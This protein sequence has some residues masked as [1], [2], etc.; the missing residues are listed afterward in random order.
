MIRGHGG[1]IHEMAQQLGCE[2]KDIFDMSSNVNPLGPP[3]GLITFLIENI[4]AI[5]ALPEVDARGAIQAFANRYGVDSDLVLAGNGTTQF[6]YAIPQV[7]E[8]RNALIIGPTYADYADACAMHRVRHMFFILDDSNGFSFDPE[9]VKNQ[10]RSA[11]TVFICNPNNPTGSLIPK[12]VLRE[13]IGE[14][15]EKHFIV[16]ES[17]LPFVIDGD[18]ESVVDLGFSNVI[19]L[20]SMSK[21]FRI[22]G[23]RIGFLISSPIIIEKFMRYAL[24][25]SANSL[26]QIAVRYL[27]ENRLETDAF[28]EESK[29][30]LETEKND[31]IGAFK[32]IPGIHMYPSTTSFV[33]AKLY[34][35]HTA[36]EVYEYL[37]HRRILIRRCTNFKGLSNRFIRIAFKTH[38]INSLL[39]DHLLAFF[40]R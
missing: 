26:A 14:F 8:T 3:A 15:P 23:L 37:A 28:I 6:I 22:P 11:D 12:T 38:E 9:Q 25:W 33:L 35:N 19:V 7:L 4:H 1:N 24:P 16:D 20:N 32:N 30:F 36:E 17:Y 39:K 13:I 34:E 5:N 2:P 21:I 40:T 29:R 18:R 10:V 31:F 27:M